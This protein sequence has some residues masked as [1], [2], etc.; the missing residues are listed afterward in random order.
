MSNDVFTTIE[1]FGM[2][3]LV[4]DGSNYW[5]YPNGG[6]PV[7]LSY[8]GSPVVAGQFGAWAPIGAEATANGYEVAWKLTG[9]D[10]Y[11][12]WYVD[13]GGNYL[14]SPIGTVSGSSTALES[15]EISFQQDLSGDGSIGVVP[16]SAP[17]VIEAMGSTSLAE[18]GSNYWLYPSS[19]APVELNYGGSPV[20]AG[21]FG[22]WAP[23]GAEATANGYEVAWKLT[24]ADQYTIWYVDD[25]GNYLSGPIGTVSGSST[26]LQSFETSFQQDLN[27]D[28]SIGVVPPSSPTVIEAFGSTSLA[29]AGSNYW[30]YPNGGSPVE[31]S[32]AGAT[33]VAGQFGAWAP[34]GAE[35]TAKGYEVAWRLTG[36]DQYTVWYFDNSG[37]YVSSAIGTV[38]GSSTA[39][40]AFE[41]SFQQDLNG[42]GLIGFPPPPS[43]TVL[44][45]F[46][47]TSLTEAG[48]NYW[49]Y[50]NDG[51]PVE[52]SYA[53]AP[54]VAGQFDQYGA[55]APIGA[56][57]TANGYEI[58]W[59]VAGA[60][61]FTVWYFDNSGN[62]LSSAIG[63]VSGSSTALEAF[64]TSFQ[65]DLNGDGLIGAP[66]PPAPTVIEAFGSTSLAKAGS[67]Y[68][69][70]P[71]GGSPIELSYAGAP[72][73]AGQFD[74]Y[75]A[76]API[77]AEATANGYEIAWKVTGVD[78]YTV[79]YFDN[80][81]NY[82]SSGIGTM[83]GSSTALEA[84]ET[85]FQQDLNGDGVIGAPPPPP[86]T[87][88]EAFGSTS[89][90]EVGSNY[91]LYP[92]GGSPVE[93]SYAGAPI[94]AGQYGA[95][96]PIGAEATATGYEVAWKP[97]GADQYTVWY[98]DDSGNYLS[99]PIGTV[100]GSSTA[101]ESFEPSFQ[102]DLN[103]DGSI[104]AGRPPSPTVI[105]AFGS[106]T[107]AEAGSNYWLYPNGGPPVELSYGG[108]PVVAGQFGAWAPIGAEATANGYEVALKLTGADQY[109]AW[110]VRQQRQLP[111]KPL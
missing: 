22:A 45:A 82:L 75:G 107:L 51:S 71:I 60:D 58:A 72:I 3:S 74:Q 102:Q 103:G 48:S 23:I 94:V 17:T 79:W 14:S 88:I 67:N 91:W 21:Q 35:T 20:V 28:G 33:I 101:L 83:S 49:L 27:G 5:L 97:T 61:Q 38:S 78:Q 57:A 76:W 53:G 73:V 87:V 7:E 92:N 15:F 90:A 68:W 104:G 36:A 30:L 99:S 70:Y 93:L 26:A 34:I 80:S 18:A 84:F 25:S 95:W 85:S 52:L 11:T 66:P 64:E 47:S 77:G 111:L 29:E 12:I 62:Y 8:G 10:Q 43:L 106:T 13:D 54:I 24:G 32:Y 96:A 105:E 59:K 1:A 89:L 86:P 6:S 108:S 69:L 39:L 110:Y 37:T 42:D 46:G 55:W 41:T 31:L 44:E 9:A 65:Q 109:T 63:T 98:F 4:E 2:T 56:E 81:G 16:P 100:S 19:G 50:P 40:E